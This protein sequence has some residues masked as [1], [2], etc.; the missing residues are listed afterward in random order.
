MKWFVTFTA[1]VGIISIYGIYMD[2]PYAGNGVIF[3]AVIMVISALGGYTVRDLRLKDIPFHR[4][5][6]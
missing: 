1:I 2:S 5:K 6:R 4:H 3:G